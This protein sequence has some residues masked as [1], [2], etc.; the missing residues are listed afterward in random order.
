MRFLTDQV[1]YAV[2]V[3][4]L[5]GLGHAAA[6]PGARRP[7]GTSE[8]SRPVHGPGAGAVE[9][10]VPKGRLK[11]RAA[12]APQSSLRDCAMRP[13]VSGRFAGNAAPHE[14]QSRRDDSTRRV[15]HSKSA[16]HRD[17]PESPVELFGTF[18]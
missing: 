13:T 16:T 15:R 12:I 7:E 2:T 10:A 14:R 5:R 6:P 18:P 8:N 17:G 1:V 9:R 4:F 3:R 11:R